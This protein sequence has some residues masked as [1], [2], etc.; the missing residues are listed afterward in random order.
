MGSWLHRAVNLEVVTLPKYLV[1]HVISESS[2]LRSHNVAKPRV[3]GLRTTD[4]ECLV[5]KQSSQ[6]RVT[7]LT[8]YMGKCLRVRLLTLILCPNV[9]P[10]FSFRLPTTLLRLSGHPSLHFS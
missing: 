9:V 8:M 7:C 5:M 10:A 4:C 1:N 3:L 2:I 6:E